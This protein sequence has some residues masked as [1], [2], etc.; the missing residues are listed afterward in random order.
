MLAC[1]KA[2]LLALG[3]QPST[4]KLPLYAILTTQAGLRGVPAVPWGSPVQKQHRISLLFKLHNNYKVTL[5]LTCPLARVFNW[6]CQVGPNLIAQQR[7]GCS[8]PRSLVQPVSSACIPNRHTH[9][10]TQVYNTYICTYIYMHIYI[11]SQ[12]AT[13]IYILRH[14]QRSHKHQHKQ[15]QGPHLVPLSG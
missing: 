6:F 15:H 12:Q 1:C 7:S 14:T 13:Q 4:G 10:Q 11:Y 8:A 2:P 3:R 5:I 9:T